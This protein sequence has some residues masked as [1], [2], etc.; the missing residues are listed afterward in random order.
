[1]LEVSPTLHSFCVI[2]HFSVARSLC[3]LPKIC[4]YP[5]FIMVFSKLIASCSAILHLAI[6]LSLLVTNATTAEAKN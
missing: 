2:H 1:M 6:S 3:G 5:V 4:W